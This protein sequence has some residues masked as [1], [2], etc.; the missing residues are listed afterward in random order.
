EHRD[1]RVFH[2]ATRRDSDGATLAEIECEVRYTLGSS[3]RGTNFLIER[4]GFVSLSPIAWF[5]QEKRWGISPGYGEGSQQT[6]FER[7]IYTEC[8]YCHTNRVQ[9]RGAT[10]A[11]LE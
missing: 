10:I 7:A 11:P 2:K 5:A 8:L 1:G 3:T 9:S 6:N 4:D